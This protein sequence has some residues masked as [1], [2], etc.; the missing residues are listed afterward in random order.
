MQGD[1]MI[2][3]TPYVHYTAGGIKTDRL[4]RVEGCED[5]FA[6][7]ECQANGFKNNGRLPGYPFTSAVVY[8]KILAEYFSKI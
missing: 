2:P 7:G 8:S 6:V 3:I 5:L 1:N 4:G